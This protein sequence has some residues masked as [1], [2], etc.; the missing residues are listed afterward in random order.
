MRTGTMTK[1]IIN[2]QHKQYKTTIT[3][4][5]TLGCW[6]EPILVLSLK[7]KLRNVNA[8]QATAAKILFR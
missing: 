4:L 1:F 3:A 5:L 8:V 7:I 6:L 2:V